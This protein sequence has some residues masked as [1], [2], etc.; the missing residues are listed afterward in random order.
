MS[1]TKGIWKTHLLSNPIQ[2]T[3][4]MRTELYRQ[5]TRI[6]GPHILGPIHLQPVI[7]HTAI[8]L[9]HASQRSDVM[10]NTSES[11]LNPELPA[12]VRIVGVHGVSGLGRLLDDVGEG[13]GAVALPRL[14]GGGDLDHE[15]QGVV[16]VVGLDCGVCG[17]D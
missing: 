1:A 13:R 11:V 9:L 4:E 14:L 3:T 12:L 5:H 8:L 6:N 7:H 16:E 10:P 2:T 17:N 15:V